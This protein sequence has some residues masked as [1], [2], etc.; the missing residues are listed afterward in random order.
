MSFHSP[1]TRLERLGRS[2]KHGA[3]LVL[4]VGPGGGRS[5][6]HEVPLNS[7]NEDSKCSSVKRRAMDLQVLPA[8]S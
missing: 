4:A 5:P 2:L 1:L 6:R 3:G 8:M 7:R